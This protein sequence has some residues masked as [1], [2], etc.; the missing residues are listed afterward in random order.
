MRYKAFIFDLDGVLTDT[1]EYHFRAWQALGKKIGIDFDRTFN[2]KLKGVGRMDSLERILDYGGQAKE[3]STEEKLALTVEKNNY[4]VEMIQNISASDLY[5]GVEELLQQ[6]KRQKIKTAIGSASQNAK[7][8]LHR[9]G[10]EK[11]L[12][13]VVDAGKIQNGKPAPDIFLDAAQNL[14]LPPEKCVGIEDSVAGITAIIAAKMYAIGIGDP[15]ILSQA[16][17]VYPKTKDII[18]DEL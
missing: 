2:D 1:S 3:F 12:D 6:I 7:T 5:E 18:I 13:C 17:I 15:K 9:L 16:D 10:I 11:Y 14:N 4:Y 8:I